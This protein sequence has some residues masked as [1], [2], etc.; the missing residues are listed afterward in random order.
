LFNR[1]LDS[2]PPARHFAICD[3]LRHF[4]I[5]DK[6]RHFA[7]CDKLR[8]MLETRRLARGA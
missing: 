1:R 5:C 4:A 2:P 7:I 6:L 3:K 8:R